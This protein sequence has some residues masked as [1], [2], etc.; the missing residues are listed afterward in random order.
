MGTR[1]IE[2]PLQYII[3]KKSIW[4]AL[5]KIP[6]LA[7]YITRYNE[8]PIQYIIGK[9]SIWWDYGESPPRRIKSPDILKFR[10]SILSARSRYGDLS[11][12]TK[13]LSIIS[14]YSRSTFLLI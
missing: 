12:L 10:F 1:Y 9:K 4:W 5:D 13:I 14:Q 6:A 7:N 2:G 8:F 3:G 11:S